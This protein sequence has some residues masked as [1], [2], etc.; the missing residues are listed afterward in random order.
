MGLLQGAT[1]FLPVSSSGHLVLAQIL[2]GVE[3]AG[4]AF[5][6]SLHLGTLL[7]ILIYFRNDFLKMFT[8]LISFRH[9]DQETRTMQSMAFFIC[10]A[11]LPAVLAV[12]LFGKAVETTLRSPAVVAATLVIGGLL[13]LWAERYGRRL[14]DFNSIGFTDSMIIGVAQAIALIPGISRSGITMTAGLFLGLNR[15]TAARFS[16]LLSAPVIFGAGIHEIPKIL[17]QGLAA[18][19][20]TY[21]FAGFISAAAS[22]YLVIAVLINYIKTSTF[23]I[24]AYYRF[25]LAGVIVLTLALT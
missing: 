5:D 19:Q 6:V 21:F 17:R 13:L 7:A 8:A 24:F 12:L 4:L 22:G 15:Q 2:L 16:F 18:D 25:A 9:P 3:D 11:T 10:L 14:R 1:E 23:D 20:M